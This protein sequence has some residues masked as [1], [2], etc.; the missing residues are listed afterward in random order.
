MPNKHGLTW[1]T[2]PLKLQQDPRTPHSTKTFL[3]S[4]IADEVCLSLEGA[5]VLEQSELTAEMRC[6]SL[7][8]R[9]NAPNSSRGLLKKQL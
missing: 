6:L 8:V 2:G 1:A 9:D 7:Q 4:R 5:T 3:R